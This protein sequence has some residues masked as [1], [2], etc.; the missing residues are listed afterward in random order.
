MSDQKKAYLYAIA[1]VLFWSTVASAFKI[2]LQYMSPVLMLLI[3]SG[4][5]AVIFFA[6]LAFGGKFHLLRACTGKDLLRSFLLGGLN[7]FLYYLMLFKAYS[8]LPAQE[9]QPLNWTWPIML[10]LLSVPILK[11]RIGLRSVAALLI[12]FAGVMFISTGGDPL[13]LHFTNPSGAFLALSSSVVWALFWIFNVRD[14][15]DERVKLFLNF[16]AGFILTAAFF[17]AAGASVPPAF[18]GIIGAAYIGLFEM[19]ITFFVWLK[20]L[21][22]SRTTAMVGNLVYA[23]PFLSLVLIHYIVGEEIQASSILGLVLILSGVA[24]QQWG[25][26]EK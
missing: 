21:T 19:G 8:L 14:G 26:R 11:Q 1:A 16:S 25:R 6:M 4:V 20:A 10:A 15:R 2:T 17:L 5:S 13:S 24:V 9:A 3:A 18:P 7:P 23:S 12:S 22:L